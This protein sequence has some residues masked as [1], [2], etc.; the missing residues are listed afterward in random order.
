MQKTLP[1]MAGVFILAN[2]CIILLHN[3]PLMRKEMFIKKRV[4]KI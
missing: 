4:S 1:L 2:R 3:N